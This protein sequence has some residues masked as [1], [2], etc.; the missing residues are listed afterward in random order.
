MLP[1]DEPADSLPG[2]LFHLGQ[3]PGRVDHDP[4]G[5]VTGRQ[6]AVPLADALVEGEV[7]AAGDDGTVLAALPGKAGAWVDVEQDD[8]IRRKAARRDPVGGA[9]GVQ[10]KAAGIALVGER[11]AFEAVADN[12]RAPL[13][14]GADDGFHQLG[15]R[16]KEGEDFRPRSQP[17]TEQPADLFAHRSAS[18]LPGEQ[19]GKSVFGEAAGN[20]GADRGL[21]GAIV[22]FEHDEPA[23]LVGIH[24]SQRYTRQAGTGSGRRP[25]PLGRSV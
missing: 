7:F 22:P 15:P 1:G 23:A 2:V 4:A 13:E 14:G 9:K 24:G 12:G 17:L 20:R 6:R 5:R 11:T 21:S 10:V 25:E 3:G 16:K 19:G 18:G 8:Q